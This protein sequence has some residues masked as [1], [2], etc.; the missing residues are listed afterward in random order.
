MFTRLNPGMESVEEIE[1]FHNER[2]SRLILYCQ[3]FRRMKDNHLEMYKTLL[4]QN[5][6][7]SRSGVCS[8]KIIIGHSRD[9]EM[10]KTIFA[11]RIVNL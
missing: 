6:G 10:A 8:L 9:A 3:E 2:L 4:M 11:E 7:V 1:S 5:T